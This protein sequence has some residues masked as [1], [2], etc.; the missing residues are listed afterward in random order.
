MS[1]LRQRSGMSLGCRTTLCETTL[2]RALEVITLFAVGLV[3]VGGGV[4]RLRTPNWRQLPVSPWRKVVSFTAADPPTG[5]FSRHLWSSRFEAP[6][7]DRVRVHIAIGVFLMVMAAV[8]I[9]HS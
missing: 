6:E 9:F 8:G 7:S 1:R 3:F 2:I 4:Y 5:R